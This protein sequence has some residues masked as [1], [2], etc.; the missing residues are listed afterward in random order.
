[1]PPIIGTI[2]KCKKKKSTQ[3][4]AGTD[5]SGSSSHLERPLLNIQAA[6]I[7]STNIYLVG[8]TGQALSRSWGNGSEPMAKNSYSHQ[9]D[10]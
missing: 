1:M 10:I 2:L 4:S 7:Y 6:L 9:A 8:T 3:H 5:I